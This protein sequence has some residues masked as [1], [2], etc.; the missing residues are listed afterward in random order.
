MIVL[1]RMNSCDLTARFAY[2]FCLAIYLKATRRLYMRGYEVQ[3]VHSTRGRGKQRYT[4]REV[5]VIAAHV[6]PVDVWYLIP[7]GRG[8]EGE[9]FAVLSDIEVPRFARDDKFVNA[10]FRG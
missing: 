2:S 7:S 10:L 9:E 6:Q 1:S 8:R 5:D 4:T 3:P